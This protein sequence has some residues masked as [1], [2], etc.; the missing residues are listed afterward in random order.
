MQELRC[1][2][3]GGILIKNTDLV[4]DDDVVFDMNIINTYS[5]YKKVNTIKCYRCKRKIKYI[6]LNEKGK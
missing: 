2:I 3:C 4:I 1:P 5:Q 6:I